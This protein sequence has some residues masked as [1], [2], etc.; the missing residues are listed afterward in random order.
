MIT[1]NGSNYQADIR[2]RTMQGN[3]HVF[4]LNLVPSSH[5]FRRLARLVNDAYPMRVI[6][7]NLDGGDWEY[8]LGK[9]AWSVT[10]TI[11]LFWDFVDA[12]GKS[13]CPEEDALR[14]KKKKR[15]KQK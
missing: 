7:V 15:E 1:E 5:E 2:L 14:K 6:I 9:M 11:D 13:S 4:I 12:L 8:H 10:V 3:I